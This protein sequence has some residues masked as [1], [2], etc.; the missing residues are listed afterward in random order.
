MS[1]DHQ[2]QALSVLSKNFRGFRNRGLGRGT[3]SVVHAHVRLLLDNPRHGIAGTARVLGITRQTAHGHLEK[4]RHAGLVVRIGRLWILNVSAL[5]AMMPEFVKERLEA[6]RAAAAAKA[7]EARK[8]LE[9]LRDAESVR[10]DLTHTSKLSLNSLGGSQIVA[11]ARSALKM[12]NRGRAQQIMAMS[13][14][15][16]G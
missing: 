14:G 5:L 9:S 11:A 2:R 3:L 4:A 7:E 15:V 1:P 6:A 13:Q 16:Q 8:L 12:Q 10:P